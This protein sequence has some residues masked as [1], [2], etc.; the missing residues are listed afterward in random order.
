MSTGGEWD[1]S[2]LAQAGRAI[3]AATPDPQ[4]LA[5]ITFLEIARLI[6]VDFF[7]LGLFDVDIYRTLILI[8]DGTRT[9]NQSYSLSTEKENIIGWVRRTR[10]ALLVNDFIKERGNLPAQPS[11]EAD[12]P[13]LSG[14]FIPLSVG[15]TTLG[16]IALQSRKPNAFSKDHL[17][18]LSILGHSLAAALANLIY[19]QETESLTLHMVLAQ[20]ISR[21]LMSLEPL[22]DRL[23]Q[24]ITLIA[25]VLNFTGVHVFQVVDDQIVLHTTTRETQMLELGS[26]IPDI[27]QRSAA[28]RRFLSSSMGDDKD[29]G[30]EI[31]CAFP[32]Q[33]VDHLLGILYLQSVDDINLE[34][35]LGRILAML[36]NQL[37]FTM[38]EARNYDERQE[39]AWMTTVL[40]EVAKHAAQPGDTMVALQAVLQL[41]TLL[42][43]T[44]WALLL[45]PDESGENVWIGVHAGFK[46]QQ[47]LTF[48][49][50]RVSIEEFEI[51]FPLTESDTP[52]QII[53]PDPLLAILGQSEALCLK[54]TDGSKL[55]GLLLM[56]DNPLPGIRPSLLAGIGHQ[57]SLRLENAR[58]IEEAALRRSLEREL[59]MARNIQSSFLPESMPKISGWELASAW[60]VAREVGGD[61][62]DIIPLPPSSKGE[63][64][65]IVI[66][67]VADKG[68]PAALY[69]ALCRTMLRSVAQ[70]HIMPAQT[71]AIVNQQLITDTRSDLFV[72]AFY[73]V[74]EPASAMITFANAGHPPPFLFKS[75]DR[76]ELIRQHGMVLGV[77]PDISYVD[78]I[79]E[80]APGDLLVLYTDGVSEAQNSDQELFGFHRLENLILSETDWNADAIAGAI[81]DRVVNFSGGRDFSDDLTTVTMRRIP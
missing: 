19:R 73:G 37:A 23:Q 68:I 67:D 66:A 21:I 72:S 71:L 35:D 64:W 77:M 6:P 31:E 79:L 26:A 55:L 42:A 76:A 60:E 1:L 47:T 7:Q 18:L 51:D 27:V 53:L 46:R 43:G 44:D 58:L 50:V 56:Q 49:S 22:T 65:G 38:L 5:E 10:E 45:L 75:G 2:T 80:L 48:E 30:G 63:R 28:E 16:I 78:Q 15:N 24:V 41:A 36:A 14:L 13:P 12:D 11:Y 54:L 69:M 61:F 4:E 32:L 59:M 9:D 39:E 52:V 29:D 62:Y 3:A 70:T 57:V 25:E 33:V 40:L 8:Q 74:W 17:Q 20:E 81:V 34:G